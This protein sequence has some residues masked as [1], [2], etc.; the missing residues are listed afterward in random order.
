MS[1]VTF[2][3]NGKALTETLEGVTMPFDYSF[4]TVNDF[5]H[6]IGT[7]Y[8]DLENLCLGMASHM[9]KLKK[10]LED[11]KK[12]QVVVGGDMAQKSA[13]WNIAN[14]ALTIN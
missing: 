11:I 12:H 8:E 1:K 4:S 6:S 2:D 9:E 3:E 13:I 5:V 14:N 10:A 7:Q